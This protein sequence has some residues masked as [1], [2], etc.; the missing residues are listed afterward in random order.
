VVIGSGHRTDALRARTPG[1]EVRSVLQQQH[2]I[3]AF[4]A[5]AG[6]VPAGRRR[7]GLPAR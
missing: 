6:A 5:L 2:A 7:T 4:G 1:L 3:E